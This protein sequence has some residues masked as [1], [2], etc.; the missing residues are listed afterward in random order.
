MRYRREG[1]K[2]QEKILGSIILNFKFGKAYVN[3]SQNPQNK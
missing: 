2:D 3:L 1:Y